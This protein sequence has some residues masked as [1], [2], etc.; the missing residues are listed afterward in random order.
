M[1][2]KTD[3]QRVTKCRNAKIARGYKRIPDL[4]SPDAAANLQSLSDRWNLNK[5]ETIETA[6]EFTE[7]SLSILPPP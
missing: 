5:T 1:T 6:L 7:R 3:S 2:A 4:I